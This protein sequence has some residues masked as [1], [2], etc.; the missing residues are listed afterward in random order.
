MFC[1]AIFESEADLRNEHSVSQQMMLHQSLLR[2]LSFGLRLSF[3]PRPEVV[4]GKKQQKQLIAK[5]IVGEGSNASATALCKDTR[6][7]T[8]L[9]LRPEEDN[10]KSFGRQPK[11]LEN[12]RLLFAARENERERKRH[13]SPLAK[14]THASTFWGRKTFGKRP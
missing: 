11:E 14:R 6:R 13:L 7:T 12:R 8:R 4:R 3:R 5:T 9:L 10:G 2:L 1:F